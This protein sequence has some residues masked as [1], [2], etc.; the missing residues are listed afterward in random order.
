MRF[1]SYGSIYLLALDVSCF[2]LVC[3]FLGLG[4]RVSYYFYERI[5]VHFAMICIRT[6]YCLLALVFVACISYSPDVG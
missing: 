1:E 6:G 2:S 5:G 3:Q 4:L